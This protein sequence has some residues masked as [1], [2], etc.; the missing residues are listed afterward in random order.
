MLNTIINKIAGA[1]PLSSSK[2]ALEAHAYSTR[3]NKNL[4]LCIS[5]QKSCKIFKFYKRLGESQSDYYEFQIFADSVA[6]Q[7]QT[8]RDTTETIGQ[9]H[10]RTHCQC[11]FLKTSG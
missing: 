5:E 8:E 4:S 1:N 2:P 10:F 9:F 11:E 3:G 6:K 7:A